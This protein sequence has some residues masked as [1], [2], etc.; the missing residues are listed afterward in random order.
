MIGL[1]KCEVKL[2][3]RVCFGLSRGFGT[4][5]EGGLGGGENWALET[6]GQ[7]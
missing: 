5:S 4:G 1:C 6:S 3:A 7:N 2:G